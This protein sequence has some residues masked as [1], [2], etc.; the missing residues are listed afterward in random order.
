MTA[1]APTA[2][3]AGHQSPATAFMSVLDAAVGNAAATLE[4]KADTWTDKLNRIAEGNGPTGLGAVADDLLDDASEGGGAKAT[5]ATEGVKAGLHGKNPVWA[6]VKG[7][8]QGGTP[9]VRAAIVT[10]VVAVVLLL[11]L[12]PVLLIVFL[13]SLLIVAAVYRARSARK[14]S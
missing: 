2:N 13:L 1:A 11:V 7:A 14:R 12:S 6:A 4:R 5:A 9:V 8:W 10:S 3:H